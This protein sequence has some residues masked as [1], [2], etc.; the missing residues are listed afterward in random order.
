MVDPA[1]Q[2]LGSVLVASN[3]SDGARA[4]LERAAHLPLGPGATIDLVHVVDEERGT[5]KAALSDNE[6]LRRLGDARDSLSSTLRSEAGKRRE[7]LLSISHGRPDSEITRVAH[8]RRFDLIIVG[9]HGKRSVRERLM[10]STAERVIRDG[11][12]SVLV[13][14]APCKGPYARSLVAV[15]FSRSARLAV[16]LAVQ[17]HAGD[18]ERIDVLHVLSPLEPDMLG[19]PKAF[20]DRDRLNSELEAQGA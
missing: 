16:E 15:D 10:G 2:R 12:V 9:R 13:V 5:D 1:Q 11:D 20:S 8:H 7:V 4:A 3:F 19:Y 6:A 18:T 17:L 14:G